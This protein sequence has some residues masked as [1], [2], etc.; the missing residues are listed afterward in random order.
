MKITKEEL[1]RIKM[2]NSRVLIK[3]DRVLN[4]KIYFESG[5]SLFISTTMELSEHVQTVGTVASAPAK[6]TANLNRKTSVLEFMPEHIQLFPGDIVYC[7]IHTMIMALGKRLD[8]TIEHPNESWLECDGQIYVIIPYQEIFMVLRPAPEIDKAIIDTLPNTK[9]PNFSKEVMAS[10]M[11]K[12]NPKNGVFINRNGEIMELIVINGYC[13]VEV[14]EEDAVKTTLILPESARK[15]S[16]GRV[17]IVMVA[18]SNKEYNEKVYQDGE[19]GPGDLAWH[20]RYASLR[21]E[22]Y[23]HIT[24]GSKDT[25][26][27]VIQKRYLIAVED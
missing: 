11:V 7:D 12:T 9:K 19:V 21:A 1:D 15:V 18:P 3:L 14:V 24:M 8:D 22:N 4:D 17:R 23:Y 13:L 10:A 2:K 5:V 6:L 26:L 20:Q 27:N 16:L 25:K